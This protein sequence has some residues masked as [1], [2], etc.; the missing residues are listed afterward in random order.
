MEILHLKKS[1]SAHVTVKYIERDGILRA[2]DKLREHWTPQG[3]V[4][5][6]LDFITCISIIKFNTSEWRNLYMY[7][8]LFYMYTL[9]KEHF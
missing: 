3:S 8:M 6:G 4:F 1:F 7:S 5:Y 9:M 2:Q